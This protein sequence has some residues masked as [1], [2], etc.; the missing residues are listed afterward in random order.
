MDYIDAL[1][2][3]GLVLV[4]ALLLYTFPKLDGWRASA[5]SWL[6]RELVTLR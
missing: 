6:S 3:G 5:D 4:K 1:I 2:T